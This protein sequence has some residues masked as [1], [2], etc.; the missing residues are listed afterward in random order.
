M[1]GQDPNSAIFHLL[2]TVDQQGL[3]LD[4]IQNDLSDVRLKIALMESKGQ[5][6]EPEQHK[7]ELQKAGVAGG[8]V[9]ASLV[10]ILFA[11]LKYFGIQV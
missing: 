11:I 5:I 6:V 3:K 8:G 4:S 10:T 7:K 2:K 1:V 9:A